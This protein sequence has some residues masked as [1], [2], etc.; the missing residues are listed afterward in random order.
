LSGLL[1]AGADT[2]ARGGSN[3]DAV[4]S[5]LMGAG[6]GSAFPIVEKGASAVVR[7]LMGRTAPKAA[8]VLATG[9]G[10]DRI[11]PAAIQQRLADLGPDA[12]L[13]DLGPNMTRQAAA[14]ASLPGEGQTLV[15]DAL[16]ARELGKN[17]R[18]QGD[19][20]AI[21]G[22]TISPRQFNTKV[23]EAQRALSP[24]YET[25]LQGASDVN[26]ASIADT[27][28][29]LESQSSGDIAAALRKV[30]SMLDD[31]SVT[32]PAAFGDALNVQ[33]PLITSA[34]QLLN[35]RHDLD[36]L[37][38]AAKGNQK[39]VLRDV[40]QMIDDE[41]SS[42]VPGIKDVDQQYALLAQQRESFEQGQQALDS[43]RSA[44]T[45]ADLRQATSSMADEVVGAMSKGTRAE[46]DRIIG[47]TANNLT[48]LKTALKGDGSWN[49]DRLVT[50]FGKDKADAL[51]NVLEREQT[52]QRT[53]N[54]ALSNSET[55]ARLAAQK[56]VSPAQ[57]GER[58]VGIVDLALRV[59]QFLAN[60]AAKSR[61]EQ[62]NQQVARAL[63]SR[64]SPDLV[65]QMMVA[66]ALADRRGLVAPAAV[67]LLTS[68]GF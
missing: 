36:D 54:A 56:D 52:Y 6:L 30:R 21:L 13:A 7:A 58:P 18:I 19:V 37:V 68:Q 24:Q 23:R 4:V 66:K 34:R 8:K 40:R 44:L 59:P 45:P 2:K 50:M 22:P 51:L 12:V 29:A 11:D 39:R 42:T 41:L 16:V 43:G 31:R 64:P 9:L 65:D 63:M 15:R 57:F 62:V 47:T 60:T 53:Y 27:I 5:A 25:A 32:M 35:V 61:S 3:T 55:A 10:R 48:A 20:N 28:D 67:P 1:I 38:G 49:R 26:V 14:I 17:A 46:I 33:A